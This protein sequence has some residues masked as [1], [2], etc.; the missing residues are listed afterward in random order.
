MHTRDTFVQLLKLQEM[1]LAVVF[2]ITFSPT[3]ALCACSTWFLTQETNIHWKSHL[4]VSQFM[5][6]HCYAASG[7]L[8]PLANYILSKHF[9]FSNYAVWIINLWL[10][11]W[12]PWII[13]CAAGFGSR[14][15]PKWISLYIFSSLIVKRQH[16]MN[17]N[18]LSSLSDLQ[19]W[20]HKQ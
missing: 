11:F 14:M 4:W 19:S 8:S 6:S 15:W 10:V 2:S 7:H 17:M 13:N 9:S 16:C 3:N 1:L 20:L 5:L 12:D 18:T